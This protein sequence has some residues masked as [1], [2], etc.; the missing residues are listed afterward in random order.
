M[1]DSQGH[2]DSA[3]CERW[4]THGVTDRAVAY[5]ARAAIGEIGGKK[6]HVDSVDSEIMWRYIT[7]Y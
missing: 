4:L 2:F 3:E 1:A 6:Q 5:T 7:P